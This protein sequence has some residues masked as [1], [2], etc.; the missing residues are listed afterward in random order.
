[1]IGSI[2]RIR[3]EI[4]GLLFEGPIFA[5][6]SARDRVQGRE[7]C[8]RLL[9][10]PFDKEKAFVGCLRTAVGRVATIQSPAVESLYELDDHEGTPFIVGDLTKGASLGERIRKLAPFSIPVS[11]A[12]AVSILEGLEAVHAADLV[13]GDISTSTVWIQADGSARIQLP[14]IW[15]SYSCSETA[16]SVVLPHM[17]PYL[18]PEVS[19]G[20]TPSVASDLYAVGVL[21]YQ[22][23]AARL[24][25]PADTPISMAIKHAT[26]PAPSVKQL[27]PSIPVVLD[28]IVKKSLTKDP[29]LR[30]T[31]ASEMLSDLRMLQDAL[32]FGKSLT[33]PIR[34]GVVVAETKQVAPRMSAVRVEKRERPDD[35]EPE[36]GDLPAWMRWSILLAVT[37]LGG[38]ILVFLYS[39]FNKPRLVAVPNLKNM[40]ATEARAMLTQAKLRMRISAKVPSEGVPADNI[41]FVSP[42]AGTKV[43]ENSDV[44]V[45]LSSG[46]R[47]VVIPDLKGRTLDEARSIL[48]QLDLTLDERS[49][50]VPARGIPRG[51]IV[52]ETPAKGSKVTRSTQ[53]HVHVSNGNDRVE[54]DSAPTDQPGPDAKAP[55]PSKYIYTLKLRLTDL[56]EPTM[57][58]VEMQDDSG[59]KTLYEG[60][61]KPGDRISIS[62]EGTGKEATFMVYYDDNL[63]KTTVKQADEGAV[64]P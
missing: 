63:V 39:N 7:V 5:A 1:M 45:K 6:Y 22:L 23:L 56:T 43:R 8:V 47:F 15:Q 21:L 50:E 61:K 12:T 44:S 54:S 46:S 49:D 2:L 35:W 30:Y 42:P 60:Q 16:G 58:R 37:V 31:T 29:A 27:N 40:S 57:V 62:S 26:E 28:E 14:G 19:A 55:E 4:T 32:R 24:P 33:W 20:G 10:P 51:Q 41:V 13:H 9:K 11:I 18:A 25:F 48:G 36:S 53:V 59:T 34:S 52:D 38:C 3:Y 64:K 17:A